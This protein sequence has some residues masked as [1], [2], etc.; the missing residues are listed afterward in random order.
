MLDADDRGEL[1]VDSTS[2]TNNVNLEERFQYFRAFDSNF[3]LRERQTAAAVTE[4]L[5]RKNLDSIQDFFNLLGARA[6]AKKRDQASRLFHTRKQLPSI[7]AKAA[8]CYVQ[9]SSRFKH[10][11]E[12]YIEHLATKVMP[13]DVNVW[14][15]SGGKVG[16]EYG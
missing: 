16:A 8:C 6:D 9:R 7:H 4:G 2:K 10:H 3:A 5:K 15:F 14:S 11:T 12:Q 13:V 1:G